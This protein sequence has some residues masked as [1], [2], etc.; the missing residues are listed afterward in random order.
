VYKI[1]NR[2]KNQPKRCEIKQQQ[3]LPPLPTSHELSKFH[4]PIAA[5]RVS[6]GCGPSNNEQ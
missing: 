6:G 1:E 5:E 4:Q 3:Q 2:A